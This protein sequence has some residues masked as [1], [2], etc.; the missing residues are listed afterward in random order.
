MK[1]INPL[2]LQAQVKLILGKEDSLLKLKYGMVEWL[3]QV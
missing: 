3:L 2:G 1:N